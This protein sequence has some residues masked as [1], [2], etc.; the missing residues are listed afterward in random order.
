MEVINNLSCLKIWFYESIILGFNTGGTSLFGTP[1]AAPASTG[2]LF[3]QQNAS[4][5]GNTV[6]GL[7]GSSNPNT[8]FGQ[9]KPVGTGFAFGANAAQPASN[10]F[11]SPQASSTGGMFGSSTAGK[12]FVYS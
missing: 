8:T 11:G 4:M 12:L 5:V 2:G 9:P 1:T 3:G 7:F 10:M 6:G